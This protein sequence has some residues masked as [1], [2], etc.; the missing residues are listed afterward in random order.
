M[1]PLSPVTIIGATPKDIIDATADPDVFFTGSDTEII[2]RAFPSNATYT[3]VFAS[4]DRDEYLASSSDMSIP[5]SAMSAPLPT[6]VF[7]PSTS[8]MTPLPVLDSKAVWSGIC[9]PSAS[10]LCLMALAMGC[11]ESCSAAAAYGS[12]MSSLPS[13]TYM[14]VTS[15]QPS[16]IVPVLSNMTASTLPAASNVAALLNSIPCLAAFPVPMIMAKGVASPSAHGHDITRTD[17]RTVKEK[18]TLLPPAMSQ[19]RQ[20]ATA[21]QMTAGTNTAAALSAILAMGALVPCA[22]SIIPTI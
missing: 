9:M 8:H 13:G 15:G 12:I 3:Q 16:V 17:M 1:S 4:A 6:T 19:S 21:M 7:V 11:S 10:A 22:P 20:D 5:I 14:E 18:D 2:P